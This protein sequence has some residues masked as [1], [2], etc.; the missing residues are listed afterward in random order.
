MSFWNTSDGESAT[1]GVTKEYDAGGGDFDPIPD[2]TNLLAF[3]SNGQWRGAKDAPDEDRHIVIEYTIEQPAAFSRRK[4]FQKLWVKD[5]DPRAKDKETADKKR[6][7]A[8]KMLAT[9]D[10]ICGG[11]LAKAGRE[12]DDDDLA[13]ALT[14]KAIII[15]SKVWEMGDSKGNWVAA[16]APK[17]G[18]LEVSEVKAKAETAKD[19]LDDNI[20]F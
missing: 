1:K 8:L 19:D 16:V 2:N 9:I 5:P 11:K 13:L 15:K 7:K 14:N 4:L 3:I 12:P 20:P 18:N 6:D 10:A 17:G